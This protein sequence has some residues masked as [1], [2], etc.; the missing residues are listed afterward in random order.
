MDKNVVGWVDSLAP[1]NINSQVFQGK[2][3]FWYLAW[4]TDTPDGQWGQQQ[5]PEKIRKTM[6]DGQNSPHERWLL[7]GEDD[8]MVD[9]V[10]ELK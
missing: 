3:L 9:E 6:P 2:E 4:V 1:I 10:Q 7:V 8:N 5:Q